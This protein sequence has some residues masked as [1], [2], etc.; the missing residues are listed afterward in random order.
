LIQFANRLLDLLVKREKVGAKKEQAKTG[1]DDDQSSKDS[2]DD[3]K[4][5]NKTNT[6]NPESRDNRPGLLCK[7]PIIFI[8]DDAYSKGLRPLKR[9]CHTFKLEKNQEALVERL[10]YINQEEVFHSNSRTLVWRMPR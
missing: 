1:D 5:Q 2:D 4:G 10:K 7:R 9:Y 6:M 3:T 8:C